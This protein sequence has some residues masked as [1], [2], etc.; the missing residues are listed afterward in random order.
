MASCLERKAQNAPIMNVLVLFI[1]IFAVATIIAYWRVLRTVATWR[2]S[3][4]SILEDADLGF[5]QIRLPSGWRPAQV[6]NESASLQAVHPVQRRYLIVISESRGDFDLTMDLAE[7][8]AR[9]VSLLTG[10][11]RVLGRHGPTNREVGGFPAQ[12]V[13]LEA[14]VD[15]AFITYLHTTIEGARAWHQ[16]IGWATQSR[17][18]RS[19]FESMLGGFAELAAPTPPLDAI[20]SPSLRLVP[21][22]RTQTQN[23]LLRECNRSSGTRH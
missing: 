16:V 7:H 11:L 5:A 19:V 17:Y 18:S 14:L 20:P 8:S 12:Q 3:P 21:I 15:G 2:R 10:A 4:S 1:T 6:L 9:T 22:R 13:E 23:R